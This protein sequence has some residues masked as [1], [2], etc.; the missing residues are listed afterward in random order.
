MFELINCG[1]LKRCYLHALRV[2]AAKSVT[3]RTILSGGIKPLQ[4]NEHAVSSI[5]IEL[6]L[7]LKKL[8]SE[9]FQGFLCFRLIG[10][11]RW[12]C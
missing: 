5:G 4:D 8:L 3:D 1:L 10:I 11:F 7:Q 6:I 12:Q 2:H 9:F